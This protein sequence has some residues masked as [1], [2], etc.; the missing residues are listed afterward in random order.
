[1]KL[2]GVPVS[3]YTKFVQ[4]CGRTP[5]VFRHSNTLVSTHLKF[6]VYTRFHNCICLFL[7][8]KN[9]ICLNVH[10]SFLH[11]LPLVYKLVC[12]IYK[13]LGSN[14]C[15][16]ERLRYHLLEMGLCCQCFVAKHLHF[17]GWRYSQVFNNITTFAAHGFV[18]NIGAKFYNIILMSYDLL[19]S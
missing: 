12:L 13:I 3:T 6:S 2:V 17:S 14:N 16:F 19:T 9:D 11:D 10:I 5:S 4:V 15:P 18:F 7:Y 8:K 1:M